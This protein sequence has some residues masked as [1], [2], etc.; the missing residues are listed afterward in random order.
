MKEPVTGRTILGVFVQDC[1]FDNGL[2]MMWLDFKGI[3]KIY[4]LTTGII[5]FVECPKHSAKP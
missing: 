3:F 5:G 2:N 4:I 1:H